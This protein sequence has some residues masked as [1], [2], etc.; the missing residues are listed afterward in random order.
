M[1]VFLFDTPFVHRTVKGRSIAV[2]VSQIGGKIVITA[3]IGFGAEIQVFMLFI[4]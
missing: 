1:A 3:E 2:M 4:V